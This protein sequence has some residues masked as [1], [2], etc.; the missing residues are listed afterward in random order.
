MAR[1]PKTNDDDHSLHSTE[2]N[3]YGYDFCA[4]RYR[5]HC[6]DFDQLDVTFCNKEL[7][8]DG[9]PLAVTRKG[10]EETLLDAQVIAGEDQQR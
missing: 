7:R 2:K 8:N 10:S 4:A 5:K 3:T 6:L 9:N 1:A